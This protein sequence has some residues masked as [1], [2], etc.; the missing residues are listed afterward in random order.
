MITLPTRV[1]SE[2]TY[3]RN[4]LL[5]NNVMAKWGLAMVGSLG[6]W[7]IN[8]GTLAGRPVPADIGAILVCR[9]GPAHRFRFFELLCPQRFQV[10][11]NTL[12]KAFIQHRLAH[13]RDYFFHHRFV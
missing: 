2:E 4:L 9:F 1:K 11:K 3:S 13:F 8:I 7:V 6:M 5:L 12:I 10:T